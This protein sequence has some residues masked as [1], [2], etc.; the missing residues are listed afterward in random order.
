MTKA[1]AL[2][3]FYS[4]FGIPAFEENSLYELEQE[5]ELPYLTYEVAADG[6]SD[7][8]IPLTLNLWDRSGSW[9]TLDALA[10]RLSAAFGR[11]GIL[12]TCDGGRILLM[13]RHPFAQHFGG[14]ADNLTK[15]VLISISAR[16]YTND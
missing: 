6:F 9:K 13:R 14:D 8:D 4:G 2:Y 10:E 11:S 7:S 5:P 15:R 3:D 12:L 1:E 16:F